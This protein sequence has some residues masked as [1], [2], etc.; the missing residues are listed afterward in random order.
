MIRG[1]PS[2]GGVNVDINIR[3]ILRADLGFGERRVQTWAMSM[4]PLGQARN[5][6]SELI[7]GIN[8][9]HDRLTITR[10]GE[11]VAVVLSPDDLASIEET[12]DILAIPGAFEA[13]DEGAREL[14]DGH[15]DDW[16]SIR[17]EFSQ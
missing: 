3:V 16:R 7:D 17:S 10:H 14:D 11:R 13:I 4:M 5:H 8:R 2:N 15:V 9:T 6:L 1:R 12:L